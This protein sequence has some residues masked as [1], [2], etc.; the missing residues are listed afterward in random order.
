MPIESVDDLEEGAIYVLPT[1]LRV[2]AW[3]K[4]LP[5]MPDPKRQMWTLIA[6]DRAFVIDPFGRIVLISTADEPGGESFDTAGMPT[7]YTVRDLSRPGES[8][9]LR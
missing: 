2:Q 7:P 3:C 5:G 6:Q 4:E 9:L 1:A 8:D